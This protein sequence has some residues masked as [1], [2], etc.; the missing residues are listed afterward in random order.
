MC[1]VLHSVVAFSV[2]HSGIRRRTFALQ[3]RFL[4][5]ADA[6]FKQVPFVV[7]KNRTEPR[8]LIRVNEQVRYLMVYIHQSY[9]AA[10]FGILWNAI[11]CTMHRYFLE[12]F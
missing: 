3:I 12:P 9:R 4:G 6:L 5:A 11:F 10:W 1:D 2:D 7:V 8:L